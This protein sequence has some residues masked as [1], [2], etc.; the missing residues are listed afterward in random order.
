VS[1]APSD[2]VRQDTYL[3]DLAASLWPAPAVVAQRLGRRHPEG[4]ISEFVCVPNAARPKLLVPAGSRRAAA[5]AVRRY[6]DL[7]SVTALVR[8]EGL[9]LAL[10]TGLGQCL[11]RDRMRITTAESAG[12]ATIQSYLEDCLGEPVFLGLSVG[13]VRAN[14]KPILAILRGDGTT[15]AFA[16][17]GINDVTRAL[18]RAEGVALRSLDRGPSSCVRAPDVLHH[19]QFNDLEVLVLG[20]LPTAGPR[21]RRGRPAVVSA[22]KEIAERPG[23]SSQP[24]SDSSYV[25]KLAATLEESPSP[26]AERLATALKTL[27]S[28]WNGQ[29]VRFGS[30]HGD[31]T[32]WNMSATDDHV[33][34][35]DW[36][37]Y[38]QGVPLGFDALHYHLHLGRTRLSADAAVQRLRRDAGTVLEPFEVSPDAVS[39]VLSCYA[40]DVATRYLSDAQTL[41]DTMWELPPSPLLRPLAELVEACAC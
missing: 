29:Q 7:T 14:R 4:V 33:S 23:V 19:G 3:H 6:S 39:A 22:M 36:E 9:R 2:P 28:R 41:S 21:L 5:G 35:W 16:K 34:V 24:L 31:W 38:R 26:S 32:P 30:W 25:E 37:R 18:V 20:A 1:R 11:M 27:R 12:A 17:V 40:V 10:R 8:T 15:L 13:P